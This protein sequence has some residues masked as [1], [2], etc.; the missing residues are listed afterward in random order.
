MTCLS[1]LS[2][3]HRQHYAT[4]RAH[5]TPQ[6]WL[7]TVFS[8]ALL[9]VTA[10]TTTV[11]AFHCRFA[12]DYTADGLIASAAD[13]TAFLADVFAAEAA[14]YAANVSFNAHT[15]MVLDGTALDYASGYAGVPHLF[16]SPA[17]DSQQLLLMAR[18][19]N[20]ST[21]ALS[22]FEHAALADTRVSSTAHAS[23]LIQ[24]SH[25]L[26]RKPDE[27]DADGD[28]S[29]QRHKADIPRSREPSR[30]LLR[31]S[32]DS[33]GNNPDRPRDRSPRVD[34]RAFIL[35]QVASKL[36]AL[37]AWNATFPGYGGYL[38]WYTHDASG[39]RLLPTPDWAKPARVRQCGG[40][41]TTKSKT[42]LRV[43]G[44]GGWGR[45]LLRVAACI[46]E[47]ACL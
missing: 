40:C 43:V 21:L 22:F 32:S 1:L 17:K 33:D 30:A 19:L 20:G 45:G 18:A 41:R 29:V 35:K 36:A 10:P 47:H 4:M 3:R 11:S 13:R 23:R 38:P 39:T 37:E 16:A 34:V 5:C 31:R 28:D 8:F 9:F 27:G 42:L 26:L 6:L 24:P 25:A 44:C 46:T 14:F 7:P 2:L 15:A 12:H